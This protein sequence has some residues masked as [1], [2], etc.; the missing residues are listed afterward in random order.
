MNESPVGLLNA[1]N[2]AEDMMHPSA[3]GQ[4]QHTQ[5]REQ[6]KICEILLDDQQP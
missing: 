1:S 2:A 3:E 4:T 5:I 6:M